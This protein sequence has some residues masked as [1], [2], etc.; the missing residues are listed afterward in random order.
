MTSLRELSNVR[1]V[2]VEAMAVA[3]APNAPSSSREQSISVLRDAA[4][5]RENFEI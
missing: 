5:W 4:S 3:W 2:Q 1:F